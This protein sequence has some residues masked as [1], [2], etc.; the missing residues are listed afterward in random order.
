MWANFFLSLLLNLII[1]ELTPLPKVPGAKRYGLADFSIPTATEDRPLPLIFGTAKVAGNVIWYGDYKADEVSRTIRS[2]L[3][4][5]KQKVPLGYRYRVGMWLSLCAATCDQI[6]EIRLGEQVVW[7]GERVLST[8]E[9]TVIDVNKS[10]EESEGQEVDN[11]FVGRFVFFNQRVAAGADYDHTPAAYLAN[12][13]GAENVPA[14]P[15]SLHV[16]WLGPSAAAMEAAAIG[17]AVDAAVKSLLGF[18]SIG[19][20]IAPLTFTV[21]RLPDLSHLPG[22][23]SLAPFAQPTPGDA[24]P[25]LIELEVLTTTLPGVGPALGPWTVDLDAFQAAASRLYYE[26]HGMSGSWETSRPIAD[27]IADIGLATNSSVEMRSDDGR[28]AIK[29]LRGD[30]PVRAVFNE[31]NIVEMRSFTRTS[32]AQAPNRVEVPFVDR[33]NEWTDRVAYAKNTA[34]IKLAGA[35]ID[36]R[37]EF[38]WTSNAELAGNLAARELVK[39]S[40]ALARVSFVGINAT[41]DQPLRP[42]DLIEVAP[43]RLGQ[44]LGMRVVSVRFASIADPAQVDIE[45]VEDVFRNGYFVNRGTSPIPAPGQGEGDTGEVPSSAQ[46]EVLVLRAPRALSQ[47]A[48]DRLLFAAAAA[49]ATQLSIDVGFSANNDPATPSNP[50]EYAEDG[51]R[52]NLAVGATLAAQLEWNAKGSQQ[53]TLT[54]PNAATLQRLLSIVQQGVPAV[55]WQAMAG[56]ELTVEQHEFVRVSGATIT[57]STTA[58]LT[59]DQRGMFD[60]WPRRWPAGSRLMV[61]TGS[62]LDPLPLATNLTADTYNGPV[63]S[64]LPGQSF[65][66]VFARYRN[67]PRL[68]ELAFSSALLANGGAPY[69]EAR[70][71]RPVVA[72]NVRLNATT[73]GYDAAGAAPSVSRASGLVLSWVNRGYGTTEADWFGTDG[74][75]ADAGLSQRV[76]VWSQD[77]PGGSWQQV[78]NQVVGSAVQSVTLPTGSYTQAGARLRAVVSVFRTAD[79]VQAAV[80]TNDFTPGDELPGRHHFWQVTA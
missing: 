3:G 56:F 9:P 30:D 10:W 40:S 74:Q 11:G 34:A 5:R 25:A 1:G 58:L 23:A 78:L 8:S 47:D 39:I 32:V 73:G 72:G 50:L 41:P 24:N 38:L 52:Y 69:G 22:A 71:M 42:G 21:Q 2:L 75:D 54:A 4:F 13:L 6:K 66:R 65:S 70:A 37:S 20:S 31:S 51:P 15:N 62:V 12:Q 35:A 63:L 19:P 68:A 59:I 7:S 28:L 45:A 57:S 14:Y 55:V 46:G 29:T 80:G 44:T 64:S 77:A 16:L 33:H 17:G 36:A 48:A 53:I 76:V 79:N 43:P 67:G 26:K 27:L 49:D 18:A 60:T 61:L